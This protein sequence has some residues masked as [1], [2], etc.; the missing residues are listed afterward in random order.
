MYT[1]L[2]LDMYLLSNPSS[3]EEIVL[4]FR[5]RFSDFSLSLA[6]FL[7]IYLLNAIESSSDAGGKP[8]RKPILH[9]RPSLHLLVLIYCLDHF[10]TFRL[11][12]HRLHRE[13]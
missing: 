13:D 11:V 12:V 10:K 2:L 6:N 8:I 9:S 5:E 3:E 4:L 7:I 1:F